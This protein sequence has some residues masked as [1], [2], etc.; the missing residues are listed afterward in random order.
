MLPVQQDIVI[1]QGA[2]WQPVM[3]WLSE[4]MTHK[5]ISGVTIGLPTLL[6]VTAHGLTGTA[7]IPVWITNVVGPRALNTEDYRCVEPRWATV[8]DAD[9]LAI[10]FDSGALQAYRSGGVLTYRAAVN[11]TGWTA[12]QEIRE[13]I[14]ADTVMNSLT[15]ENGGITLGADGTIT[16]HMTAAQSTAL[17]AMQGVYNLELIDPNGIVTRFAQGAVCVSP[18]FPQVSP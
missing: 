3:Q 4:N 17:G 6:T 11:L 1:I 9:T 7:Q 13:S 18:D 10:D 12:R 16:R 14:D 2:D 5:L 8:V 15:T